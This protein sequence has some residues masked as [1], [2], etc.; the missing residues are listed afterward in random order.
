[1]K[2]NLDALKRLGVL[3]KKN[4]EN[5]GSKEEYYIL[6]HFAS[7]FKE[8]D[9]LMDALEASNLDPSFR[10]EMNSIIKQALEE[11]IIFRI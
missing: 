7:T 2:G 10:S 11:R 1:M 5:E 3:L 8:L 9:T 6:E 4:V